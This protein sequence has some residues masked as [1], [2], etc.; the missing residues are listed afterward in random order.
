MT[1]TINQDYLEFKNDILKDIREFEKKINNEI[2]LKN[3]KIDTSIFDFKNKIEKLEKESKNS[4]FN[5]IEIKSQLNR[6]NEYFNFKQKIE[7][8]IFNHDIKLKI[9][10]EEIEKVKTKYDKIIDENLIIPGVLGGSSKFKNLKDYI[11]NNNTEIARIKYGLEEE[12][13]MSVEFKKK[14]E[15]IPKTMINMVDS[16]VRR[17]NEYTELKQKDIEKIIDIKLMD[18]NDKIMEIKVEIMENKKYFEEKIENLKNIIM[19]YSN[20]KNEIL[21]ILEEKIKNMNNM[22]TQK[23]ENFENIKLEIEEIKKGMKKMDNQLLNNTQLINEII[24]NLKNMKNIRYSNNNY[25][26]YNNPGNK[27]DNILNSNNNNNNNVFNNNTQSILTLSPKQK[28]TE[29]NLNNKN[30]VNSRHINSRRKNSFREQPFYNRMKDLSFSEI[31]NNK[32]NKDNEINEIKTSNETGVKT[33]IKAYIS[34]KKI[35]N[36]LILKKDIEN[37]FMNKNSDNDSSSLEERDSEYAK[38]TNKKVSR[39]SMK[40]NKELEKLILDSNKDN[41]VPLSIDED[42]CN[43][44]KIINNEERNNNEEKNNNEENNNNEIKDFKEKK[45]FELNIFKS[46]INNNNQKKSVIRNTNKNLKENISNEIKTKS[47]NNNK[48]ISNNDKNL[49][50]IIN[51]AD[52]INVLKKNKEE[53]NINK[54]SKSKNDNTI[55]KSKIINNI[56]NNDISNNKNNVETNTL[57]ENMDNNVNNNIDD[58]AP[59]EVEKIIISSKEKENIIKN[60]KIEDKK[61]IKNNF[62]DINDKN[63]NII[64]IIKNN[65]SNINIKRN[66]INIIN[67]NFEQLQNYDGF[68]LNSKLNVNLNLGAVDSFLNSSQNKKKKYLKSINN[69]TSR[70]DY[71]NYI[72]NQSLDTEVKVKN[73]DLFAKARKNI[74]DKNNIRNYSFNGKKLQS[75]KKEKKNEENISPLD[76]LYKS[77]YNKNHKN[78]SLSQE[79]KINNLKRITPVFG[80]TVYTFYEKKDNREFFKF[81]L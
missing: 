75:K 7:N 35:N 2:K 25:N 15:A 80:R 22:N 4:S 9:S 28:Q 23:D 13:K 46:K 16:A 52:S 37:Q 19:S 47:F 63:N 11:H 76:N 17:S 79:Q 14:F 67:N 50:N 8:M 54:C 32:L 64:N 71:R 38:E 72:E 20:I 49:P 39:L 42:K 56:S 70:N 48:S 5:I 41:N 27:I 1:S 62:I 6:F 34:N 78:D 53:K 24:Y 36:N 26:I 12:K 65:N 44:N 60:H 43:L 31:K 45:Q 66:T 68:P 59:N 40:T 21:Q 81:S 18:Y 69:Y 30:I 29:S 10:V 55:I 74:A 61:K 77:Y 51:Y 73:I 57:D 3:N 33:N 58:R